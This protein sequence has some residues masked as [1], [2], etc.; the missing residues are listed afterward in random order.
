MFEKQ[1]ASGTDAAL[2][3]EETSETCGQLHRE[4]SFL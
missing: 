3:G 1:D 4:G 2:D